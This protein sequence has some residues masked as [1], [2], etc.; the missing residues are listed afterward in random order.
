MKEEEKEIKENSV[1]RP[2]TIKDLDLKSLKALAYD[3]TI[4]IEQA[5]QNLQIL[6][7]EIASKL[8]QQNSHPRGV[9]TL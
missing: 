4:K 7:A 6:N 3:E 8:N 9:A 5:R 2:K 1:T